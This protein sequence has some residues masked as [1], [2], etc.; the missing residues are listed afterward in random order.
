MKN[1]ISICVLALSCSAISGLDAQVAQNEN[2][3]VGMIIPS[4]AAEINCKT[5]APAILISSSNDEK[6]NYM[7]MQQAAEKRAK[8]LL[9][10]MTLV[11]KLSML[12]GT[13]NFYIRGN[14]RLGIPEILMTDGPTGVKFDRSCYK[15]ASPSTS[16]PA[17]IAFAAS[18]NTKLNHEFGVAIGQECRARGAHILL[19][20]GVNIYRA[21]MGGRNFE[22]LGEDPFLASQMVV[23]FIKGVQA[24]GVMACVKHFCGN[25]QE[26][27]R[28]SVS[29]DIDERTLREIYLPAFK[30]AVQDAGV[31]SLMSAYNL[32]NGLH[33]TEN[34]YI[35]NEILKGEWGFK[36]FVMSDWGATH[37]LVPAANGG[38]DLEMPGGAHF[39][40]E[41][42]EKAINA[43]KIELKTINDKVMRMLRPM[44]SMGF[45]D[46]N[47]LDSDIPLYLP[48]AKTVALQ[49]VR[50]GCVLLKNRDEILPFDSNKIKSIAVIGPNATPAVTGG[51][52]SS[53][54]KPFRA[55]SI[56]DG[57]ECLAG[58][59]IKVFYHRGI[60]PHASIEIFGKSQYLTA[61]GKKGL[62]A[63]YFNNAH[64]KGI[65]DGVRIDKSINFLWGTEKPFP[66]INADS[67]SVRW[68]GYI[69]PEES[70]CY[71]FITKSD[72]GSRL[73]VD[74]KTIVENWGDHG[75]KECSGTMTLEAGRKYAIIIEYYDAGGNA[76]M[77]AG[78]HKKE[79]GFT[80]ACRL[81]AKADV[82]V[83]CAGY[84]SS[85]EFEGADRDFVLP[86]MQNELIKAVAGINPNTVVLLTSGG[87]VDMHSWLDDIKGLL[88]VWYPGQEGG[89][90]IG[91]ILFGKINPSGK[92][93]ATFERSWED[94]PCYNTYYD[95]DNNQ[96][97]KYEE[98]IF[99][100]YRGYEKNGVK[101]QFPFGFG[102]SYTTFE[103]SELR[104]NIKDNRPLSVTF[105][106]TNTGNRDGVEI[107][108]L[109]IGDISCSVPRPI[110]ELKGFSRVSL[111]P[112]ETKNITIPFQKK[113]LAF[114]DVNKK[115]WIVEPG[116]FK[117]YIGSSS[118][119]IELEGTFKITNP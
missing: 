9:G 95:A 102:L 26:W 25:N 48:A 47:Q 51:G 75:A 107:P 67:F 79:R 117:V 81:A 99:I 68:S 86:N 12:G 39:T 54:V 31:H 55:V 22:Y 85:T 63:E 73:F 16:Y 8:A 96:R 90:G 29:S 2:I 112:G 36:G 108:Q 65:A 35:Q 94:N 69:I 50:E 18:W 70:G 83:V 41:K 1:Y 111:T 110:K 46:R 17:T 59:K 78:W 44:F 64:L 92:L 4:Q 60:E 28:Y 30:A 82:V 115:S 114:Y 97:V 20:P 106:I 105:N 19:S 98:G 14:K 37:S 34:S 89:I 61:D 45:F 7:A 23:P 38:L 53:K 21:P 43:G 13:K 40:P 58:D 15:N 24:Q 80:D 57:I 88:H 118:Q 93:P 103:Y 76:E 32:V 77:H 109:Y 5:D 119:N 100:G 104:I 62:T 49:A 10:R 3:A 84:D 116:E 74:G 113:N 101:P 27:N 52:G 56:L 6:E 72:D 66:A 87:N 91:E 42:L 71:E 11:E 33:A